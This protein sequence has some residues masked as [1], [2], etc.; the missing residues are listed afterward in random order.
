[1]ISVYINGTSQ[2]FEQVSTVADL[3]AALNLGGKRIAIECNGEIVPR[4]TFAQHPLH[5][6]DR[7]EI[8]VA[9]G[10]G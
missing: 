10:G 5:E 3:V 6:G 4:S 8:V 9:V 2:A 7:I 1:M